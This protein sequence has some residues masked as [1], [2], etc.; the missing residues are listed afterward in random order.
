MDMTGSMDDTILKQEST[1]LFSAGDNVA[2]LSSQ[3]LNTVVTKSIDL[4]NA[5]G[6]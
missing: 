5:L 3:F 4:E 6:F 1:T 2:S